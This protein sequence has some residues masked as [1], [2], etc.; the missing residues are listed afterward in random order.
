MSMRGSRISRCAASADLTLPYGR[1]VFEYN[2]E[3]AAVVAIPT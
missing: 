1:V 2:K 3:V